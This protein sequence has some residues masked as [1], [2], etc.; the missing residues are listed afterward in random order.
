MKKN[1]QIV[2]LIIDYFFMQLKVINYKIE[3][4]LLKYTDINILFNNDYIVFHS[5]FAYFLLNKKI[6]N[7]SILKLFLDI[8]KHNIYI[9]CFIKNIK[10]IF[11]ILKNI[12]YGLYLVYFIRLKL[13]GLTARGLFKHKRKKIIY[14]KTAL[15]NYKYI[16]FEIGYNHF[17]D[18]YL[19]KNI[20]F[21]KR[22][23]K[24]IIFTTSKKILHSFVRFLQRVKKMTAY[25]L[26][27]MKFS[28]CLLYTSPSPRDA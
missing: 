9:L 15:K 13:I 8:K 23:K 5:K 7:K 26:K 6:N 24:F 2:L 1:I 18:I 20:F 25:K 4:H 14:K 12:F 17:L 11:Y 19:S 22:K 16:R 21:R 27:G 10:N 28:G 3:K